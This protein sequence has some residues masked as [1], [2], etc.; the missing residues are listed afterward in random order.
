[1]ISNL[2]RTNAAGDRQN[3]ALQW[4][5]TYLNGKDPDIY[6]EIHVAPLNSEYYSF[7]GSSKVSGSSTSDTSTIS[8]DDLEP[9][10][11]KVRVT[12]YV[13]DASSSF[14]ITQLTIPLASPRPEISI[15]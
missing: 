12:G 3:A 13:D 11:Y 5:I 8:I 9:G 6:E 14:N 7:R 4:D 2:R 1:V 10:T 15:R